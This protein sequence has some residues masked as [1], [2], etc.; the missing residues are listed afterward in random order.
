MFVAAAMFAVSGC[1][2]DDEKTVNQNDV[3]GSWGLETLIY[4]RTI[5]TL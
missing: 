1:S 3:I 4:S 2:K 5:L